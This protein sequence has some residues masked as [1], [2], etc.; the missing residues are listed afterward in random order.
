MLNFD[1]RSE[2]VACARLVFDE[3]PLPFADPNPGCES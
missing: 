1:C 3:Q 2:G